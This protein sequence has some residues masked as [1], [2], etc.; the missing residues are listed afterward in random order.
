MHWWDWFG[1]LG[2][3]YGV[4]SEYRSANE[5]RTQHSF[6]KGLKPAIG[7]APRD[8]IITQIDDE[9]ARLIPTKGKLLRV[10]GRVV[11]ICVAV[12]VVEVVAMAVIGS[13]D[14]GS[15]MATRCWLAMKDTPPPPS[16]YVLD[17]LPDPKGLQRLS[18]GMCK[19]FEA[20]VVPKSSIDAREA[21]PTQGQ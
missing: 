6:L 1:V 2:V 5:R 19:I 18:M 11:S 12:L 7:N 9:M 13:V 4:W 17:Q 16:G 10:I 20:N 14:N 3:L 21:R 15:E 8:E